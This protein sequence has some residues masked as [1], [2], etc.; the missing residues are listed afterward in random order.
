M[1]RKDFILT[2]F[3]PILAMFGYKIDIQKFFKRPPTF[4]SVPLSMVRKSFPELM[5][6]NIIG[7]QPMMSTTSSLFKLKSRYERSRA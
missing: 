1:N 4:E 5:A 2:L 7:V 6:R 3:S